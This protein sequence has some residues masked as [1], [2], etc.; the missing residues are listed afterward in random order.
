MLFCPF[1]PLLARKITPGL[2]QNLDVVKAIFVICRWW[3]PIYAAMIE[4]RNLQKVRSRWSLHQCSKSMLRVISSA[5]TVVIICGNCCDRSCVRNL[6][7]WESWFRA[8]GT[9]LSRSASYLHFRTDRVELLRIRGAYVL[10]GAWRG[11]VVKKVRADK[12]KVR[13]Q[14]SAKIQ[15][16]WRGYWIRSRKIQRSSSE[17]A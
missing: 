12:V 17:S 5:S 11:F 14:A 16:L 2:F 10:Q 6:E 8:I 13:N 1:I 4:R 9:S 7:C 3:R 15:A